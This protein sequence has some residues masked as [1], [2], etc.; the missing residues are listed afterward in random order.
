MGLKS[1]TQ[2]HTPINENIVLCKPI[3]NNILCRNYFIKIL[4]VNFKSTI[5]WGGGG[6]E[7]LIWNAYTK[8]FVLINK[9]YFVLCICLKE[10]LNY[11]TLCVWQRFCDYVFGERGGGMCLSH[12]NIDK[13]FFQIKLNYSRVLFFY[14]GFLYTFNFKTKNNLNILTFKCMYFLVLFHAHLSL[15]TFK[16]AKNTTVKHEK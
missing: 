14:R 10:Y 15:S 1:I 12:E 9:I 4:N 5:C 6:E 13:T 2:S 11:F 8:F 7:I 3:L 16:I